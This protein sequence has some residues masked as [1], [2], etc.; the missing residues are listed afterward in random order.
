M[1]GPAGA[2]LLVRRVGRRAARVADGRRDDAGE[3][4][5]RLLGA[6]EAAET[7][8]RGL[9]AVGPRAGEGSAE[10]GV[11]AGGH[12]RLRSPGEG[13]EG[14]GMDVGLGGEEPHA[15]SLVTSRDDPVTGRSARRLSP[16]GDP[17]VVDFDLEKVVRPA[18]DG[19]EPEADRSGRRKRSIEI[20]AVRHA[21][22]TSAA[23]R[24]H[25]EDST[26]VP[27]ERST[28]AWRRSDGVERGVMREDVARTS[29]AG[30]PPAGRR[31]LASGRSSA[32]RGRWRSPI[33]RP[34]PGHEARRGPT[35]SS[36][37]CFAPELE[38][39]AGLPR[40]NR[41][42]AGAVSVPSGFDG[43]AAG[44]LEVVVER[45]AARDPDARA[46]ARRAGTTRAPSGTGRP[47]CCGPVSAR[48][49][50]IVL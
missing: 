28:I 4:P 11:R 43:P 16:A 8:D 41:T 14:E 10:D 49:H 34:R 7:E 2:G 13:S 19:L 35:A 5:E 47:P 30:R 48:D 36:L 6:P 46:R 9:R 45:A 17:D 39:A 27:S 42:A 24:R 15:G 37:S 25:D 12:D 44:D 20:D 22:S 18:V 3:L 33:S 23:V 21:P 29:A 32:R 40:A 31:S 26:C 50:R 38:V 1:A